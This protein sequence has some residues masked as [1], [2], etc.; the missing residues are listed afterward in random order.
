MLLLSEGKL[1]WHQN[2]RIICVHEW[3][4]YGSYIL[5]QPHVTKCR[6]CG[7]IRGKR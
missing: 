1:H 6:H 4:D 5:G 7:R 2:V 3:V